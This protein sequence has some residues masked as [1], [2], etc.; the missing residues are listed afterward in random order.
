MANESLNF[1]LQRAKTEMII[2]TEGIMSKYKLPAC[3]MDGILS[4]LMA[5]IRLQEATELVMNKSEE[6]SPVEKENK[7]E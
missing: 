4:S 7:D 5:D 6:D 2:S 3:L 1:V